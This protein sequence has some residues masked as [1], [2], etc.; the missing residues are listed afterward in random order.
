MNKMNALVVGF[1]S[2]GVLGGC[3]TPA[4]IS[5]NKPIADT[6]HT[7]HLAILSTQSEIHAKVE[8]SNVA[9]ATG[10]GLIPALID[11]A[12]ESSRSKDA[13]ASIEPLR[14]VL[15]DYDFGQA[16]ESSLTPHLSSISWLKVQKVDIVY[17]NKEE[18]IKNLL[19]QEQTEFLM[20]IDPSYSVASDFSALVVEATLTLYSNPH[21][22][23][24]EVEKNSVSPEDTLSYKN[25]VSYRYALPSPATDPEVAIAEWSKD[26]GALIK[27][28]LQKGVEN[29]SWQLI[30]GLKRPYS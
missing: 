3:E 24:D 12:I 21:Q 2:I 14:D 6:S 9:Q 1:L 17:E 19:I 18:P 26:Q 23:K 27:K 22:G 10:G 30:E 13:E 20:I 25:M 5:L 7:S 11:V 29:I 8:K 4:H 15:L 16:L 28:A